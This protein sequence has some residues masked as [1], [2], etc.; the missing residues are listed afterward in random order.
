MPEYLIRQ[1]VK[2][3]KFLNKAGWARGRLSPLA[4]PGR[5]RPD[6]RPCEASGPCTGTAVRGPGRGSRSISEKQGFVV[7]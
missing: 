6:Q 7:A 1:P 4:A 3:S 5:A 2:F